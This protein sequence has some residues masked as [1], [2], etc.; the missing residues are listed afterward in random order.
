MGNDPY[1]ALCIAANENRG[2]DPLIKNPTSS[3]GGINQITDGTWL[4]A[5]RGMGVDWPLIDKYD[6]E[7]NIHV[8]AWILKNY[9]PTRWEVYNNGTCS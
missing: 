5:T 6:G 2:F 8:G 7:K 3:A 9:G 4:D 1:L